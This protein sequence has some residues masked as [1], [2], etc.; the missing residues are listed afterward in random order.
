MNAKRLLST[1]AVSTS[2]LLSCSVATPGTTAVDDPDSWVE[3][4]AK[5][6]AGAV[7][8]AVAG[9][10]SGPASALEPATSP[11]WEITEG[12]LTIVSYAQEQ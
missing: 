7:L 12:H 2:L 3:A 11:D 4:D 5:V 1:V 9:F 10:E 6:A 8:V